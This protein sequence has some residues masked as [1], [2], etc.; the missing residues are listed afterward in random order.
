[1]FADI[2]FASFVQEV[3]LQ[4]LRFIEAITRW[5]THDRTQK[6]DLFTPDDLLIEEVSEEDRSDW[7]NIILDRNRPKLTICTD[8]SNWK[9]GP[10]DFAI[11]Q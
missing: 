11:V 4:I 10:R 5:K 2:L 1:M 3:S 6:V 8:S 9:D 7:L